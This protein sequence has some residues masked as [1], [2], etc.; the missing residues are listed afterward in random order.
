[1]RAIYGWHL[2]SAQQGGARMSSRRSAHEMQVTP[3]QVWS[4]LPSDL[5]TRIAD[6][7]AL[8]AV[9]M[10]VARPTSDSMGKEA[11]CVQPTNSAKNRAFPS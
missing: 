7:L 10:V 11:A 9:N 5:R 8:L 3:M 6:L 2:V 1:M 4:A